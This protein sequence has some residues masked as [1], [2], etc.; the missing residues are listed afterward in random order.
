VLV[1]IDH[2]SRAVVAVAPLEG[3]NAGW[4]IDVPEGTFL[5][6][7]P[8]KHLISDQEDTFTGEAFAMLLR[9]WDVKHRFG[10]VGKHGPIAVTERL[11]WTLRER[12]AKVSYGRMAGS[13]RHAYKAVRGVPFAFARGI[14][15]GGGGPPTPEEQK[16]SHDQRGDRRAPDRRCSRAGHLNAF[17]ARE[18]RV[19]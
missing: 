8:P 2:F 1:A 18:R 13:Y 4:A 3:P 10:A 14:L 6:H 17:T 11:S 16:G 15:A 9:D 7:G 12:R 5:R 19:A